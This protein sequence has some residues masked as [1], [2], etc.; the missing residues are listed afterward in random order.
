MLQLLNNYDGS[1]G[2]IAGASYVNVTSSSDMLGAHGFISDAGRLH[3]LL[4]CRQAEDALTA[5]LELPQG[6]TWPP[7]T[8]DP[9]RGVGASIYRLDAQHKQAGSPE[10][11][12]VVQGKLSITMPAVS[13][14]LVVVA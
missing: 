10:P 5:V 3:V 6:G 9:A 1:G 4:I 14:A 11:A 2:S 8:M 7:G 13:A 12:N